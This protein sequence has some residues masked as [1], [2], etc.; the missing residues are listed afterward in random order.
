MHTVYNLVAINFKRRTLGQIAYDGHENLSRPREGH[1]L[2]E[3]NF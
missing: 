1:T 3:R 2:H